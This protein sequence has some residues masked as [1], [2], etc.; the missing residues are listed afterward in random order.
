MLTQ[1]DANVKFD[2]DANVEFDI[3]ANVEFDV[4]ANIKFNDVELRVKWT[5]CRNYVNKTILF[6]IT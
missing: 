1:I 2:I 5:R 6:Y 4:D 3:N